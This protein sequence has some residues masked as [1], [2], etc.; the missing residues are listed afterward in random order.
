MTKVDG[1]ARARTSPALGRRGVAP[2]SQRDGAVGG[3]LQDREV[4]HASRAAFV[5]L[6][7]LQAASS[8]VRGIVT[9]AHVPHNTGSDVP[10]DAIG[11]ALEFALQAAV[12]FVA[13]IIIYSNRD[14]VSVRI[15]GV[16][17]LLTVSAYGYM[18]SVAD[19]SVS[20]RGLTTLIYLLVVCLALVALRP[21]INDLK[22]VGGVGVII[23]LAAL[24]FGLL[25]PATAFMPEG[26]NP[27]KLI[28]SIPSLAGPLSHSNIL[29]LVLAL[30]APFTLLF[31]LRWWRWTSFLLVA[32]VIF[33][34]A[35]RTALLALGL[36]FVVLV[37]CELFPRMSRFIAGLLLIVA[38]LLVVAVPLRTASIGA[39]VASRGAVWDW[40]LGRFQGVSQYIWGVNSTFPK[41]SDGGPLASAHNLFLQWLYVGGLVLVAIGAMLFLAYGVRVVRM[42]PDRIAMVAVLYLLTLLILSISEYVF[43]LTPASPLFLVIVFPFVCVLAQSQSKPTT[44]Q[45]VSY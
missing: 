14:F 37:L 23:A 41:Y 35:S 18:R 10:F 13:G 1:D 38:G 33:L 15:G 36:S 8:L 9:Y 24:L 43:F 44:T 12:V 22:V 30:S 40:V 28:P 29:G 31:R 19:G 39:Y 21:R 34:S 17:L 42:L 4:P 26:W 45:G 5:W 27:D 32:T 3:R 11:V 25:F 6:C 16:L 7:S 2:A 20:I